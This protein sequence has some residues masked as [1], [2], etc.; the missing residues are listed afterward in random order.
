MQNLDVVIAG[1]SPAASAG[2][3]L[4]IVTAIDADRVGRPTGL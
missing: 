2:S 3:V 1:A 4:E